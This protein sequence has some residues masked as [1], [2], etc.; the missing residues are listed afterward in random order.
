MQLRNLM[1]ILKL[2]PLGISKIIVII[3]AKGNGD[4]H[5]KLLFV[6]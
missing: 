2:Y 5:T 1:V 4:F 6:L 3:I